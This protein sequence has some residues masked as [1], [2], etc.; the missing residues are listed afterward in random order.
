[1][2][3]QP[4]NEILL[5]GASGLLGQAITSRLTRPWK[6]LHHGDEGWDP[7]KGIC[8]PAWV[9]DVS[10]V[11][12][13]AGEPIAARR[14]S[15]AQKQKI[16]DSR[17]NG[18]RALAQALAA[19]DN[20]P[21]CLICASAIGFYGN[22]GE[23][24][25][26]E[27][28]DAGEGYLS[29]LVQD[30]EAAAEPARQAGIRVVHLRLGI[31]LSDQGGALAKMLPAFKLGLGGKLG[32]G[33]MWMSWIHIEDA[34][35]AFEHVLTHPEISGVVNLTAPH[36]VRNREFTRS[37]AEVLKKPAVL[38]VPA[39]LLKT[40]LGEMGETLLLSSTRCPA[41][42]LQK[43]DFDFQHPELKPALRQLLSP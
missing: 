33:R 20:K 12:H 21:E 17:V 24:L 15:P 13:L 31:V 26:N 35:R 2:E 23:E 39:F 16:Y 28:A 36:S 40:L 41:A 18:T 43:L 7:E 25:L 11:I 22:R 3:P 42:A 6:A 10:A 32:N 14:W 34:A 1:M 9:K 27:S 5:T 37:L 38:P 19:S 30:W 8:N 29:D 4:K